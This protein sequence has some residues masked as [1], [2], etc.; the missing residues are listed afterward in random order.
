MGGITRRGPKW[1]KQQV[2]FVWAMWTANFKI[3]TSIHPG[4]IRDLQT[5]SPVPLKLLG[6]MDGG[7]KE[8]RQ[9]HAEYSPY[10]IHGEWFNLPEPKV[11]ELLDRFGVEIPEDL[12][13]GPMEVSTHGTV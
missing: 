11:W 1:P 2:Y 12:R 5:A 3:G 13:L 7:L 9:L 4:R 6:L 10:R 8:E